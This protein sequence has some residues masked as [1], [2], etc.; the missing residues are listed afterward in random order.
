MRVIVVVYLLSLTV[1][2]TAQYKR[3][4]SVAVQSESTAFPLT[5]IAPIHP[6]VDVSMQLRKKE[7]WNGQ[8]AYNVGIGWYYHRRISNAFYVK[9][10]AL[11]SHQLFKQLSVDAL[12]SI[13]YMHTFYPAEL[14]RLNKKTGEYE[15]IRQAGRPHVLG[16]IGIGFTYQNESR[17]EPF[18]RQEFGVETPFANGIPVMMH[19]FS[20]FGVNIKI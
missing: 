8:L 10:E 17:I 14:Y 5:R 9:G 13:A 11:Y 6:G 4:I 15:K 12:A 3:Q 1:F 16:L 7:K 18:I 2:S 20:K 19:S